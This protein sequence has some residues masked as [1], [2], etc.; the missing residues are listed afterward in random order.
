MIEKKLFGII[1][2]NPELWID[3]TK[4]GNLFIDPNLNRLYNICENVYKQYEKIDK[5]LI[6][7]HINKN[8]N[9]NKEMFYQI[10]DSEFYDDNYKPYLKKYITDD[11]KIRLKGY[12]NSDLKEKAFIDLKSDLKNIIENTY[13]IDS[14]KTTDMKECCKTELENLK[15]GEPIKKISSG[16]SYID[17]NQRGYKE[18]DFIIIGGM[19]S[20]G[21]TS[22]AINS[23]VKQMKD[24]RIGMISCEMTKDEIVRLLACNKA[25]IDNIKVED[26]LLNESEKKRYLNALEDLYI[27]P[28]FIEDEIYEWEE[29]R[30]KIK[31][32]KIEENIDIIYIDYL[33]YIRHRKYLTQ[34]DRLEAITKG[35]KSSCKELH[36]PHVCIAALNKDGAG[37]VP[38]V[39][40]IKGN[41]DCGYDADIIIL[42]STEAE[43]VDGNFNE[44]HVDFH[45]KKNRGGRR[46]VR[47]MKYLPA[48]RR[49]QEIYE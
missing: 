11:F 27:K 6:I 29:I 18:T 12:I 1:L 36:I 14:K 8:N 42:L 7:D 33:H 35:I 24:Y 2:N 5:D 17:I 10:Y 43:A 46:G 19:E 16:I 15:D 23:I 28:V 3:F 21:K 31:T 22:L 26:K 30:Q 40:N 47:R 37:G 32:L 25:G 20:A 38:E 44:R 49:F 45:F 34:Y 9:F 39:K 41:N 4:H 48:F 13:A